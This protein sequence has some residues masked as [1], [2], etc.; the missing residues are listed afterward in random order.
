MLIVLFV[1]ILHV[2]IIISYNNPDNTSKKKQLKDV[3]LNTLFFI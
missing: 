3:I 2:Y 1:I